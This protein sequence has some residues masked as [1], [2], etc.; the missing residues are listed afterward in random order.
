MLALIGWVLL[1]SV[2]IA[3]FTNAGRFAQ[4]QTVKTVI[5]GFSAVG[6]GIAVFQILTNGAFWALAFVAVAAF[7]GWRW[8]Q[9]KHAGATV[10]SI[11]SR[12]RAA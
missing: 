1:G 10:T 3:A 6:L 5:R 8:Y 2:A 12:N 11:F 4:D 9:R 7:F